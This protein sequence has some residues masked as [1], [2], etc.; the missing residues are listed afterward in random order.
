MCSLVSH[1]ANDTECEFIALR[2]FTYFKNDSDN[3]CITKSF[4]IQLGYQVV[5]PGI[6]NWYPKLVSR[7]LVTVTGQAF[8]RMLYVVCHWYCCY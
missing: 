6:Q 7:T 3:R 2:H 4:G 5:T 8:F 1:E